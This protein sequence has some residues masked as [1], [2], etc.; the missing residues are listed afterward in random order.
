MAVSNT[1]DRSDAARLLHALAESSPAMLWISDPSGAFSFVSRRWQ[2]CTG[3]SQEEALGSGWLSLLHPEDGPPVQDMFLAAHER[4]EPFSV[5]C[6][7]R[8]A[9]G[10]YHWVLTAGRPHLGTGGEFLG[11]AGTVIDIHD[12]KLA[13]R[14]LRHT[15]Q[16]ARFLA[17]ASVA[18]TDL[19]DF[20]SILQRLA[21]LAVP[22]FADWC[23]VDLV[24]DDGALER[25]MVVH[26]QRRQWD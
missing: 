8:Y 1:R 7:L 13:E 26:S 5:D 23:A 6:R 19:S 21:S 25:L 3:Q 12:R 11:F 24:L 14:A 22:F 10:G 2:E 9:D 16:V 4:R 15:Q 18:L 20:R 17:N